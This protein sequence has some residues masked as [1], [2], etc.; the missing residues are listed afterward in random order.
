MIKWGSILI[1][2]SYFILKVEVSNWSNSSI[3]IIR[4][5]VFS[6]W[7]NMKKIQINVFLMVLLSQSDRKITLHIMHL[8]N[9]IQHLLI[10]DLNGSRYLKKAKPE[11]NILNN[12]THDPRLYLIWPPDWN[13]LQLIKFNAPLNLFIFL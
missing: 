12:S 11:S 4:T 1:Q 7:R 8:L 3:W 5:R 10:F 13:R 9:F 2:R 6:S